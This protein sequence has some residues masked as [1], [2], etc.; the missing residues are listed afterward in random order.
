MIAPQQDHL[1]SSPTFYS[2]CPLSS[3]PHRAVP[4]EA[5][6]LLFGTAIRFSYLAV[7][8]RIPFHR[9]WRSQRLPK[10]E[11]VSA[12]AALRSMG[13][14]DEIGTP[15]L[16]PSDPSTWRPCS[17]PAST[18]TTVAVARHVRYIIALRCDT[19]PCA[20]PRVVLYAGRT[21]ASARTDRTGSK[22][23]DSIEV[24]CA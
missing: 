21:T 18:D 16:A 10:V 15:R 7:S 20:G 19:V 3:Q 4:S 22:S 14:A 6:M 8:P 13:R 23:N 1:G 2:S 5:Q 17:A 9:E 12:L 24:G 11:A